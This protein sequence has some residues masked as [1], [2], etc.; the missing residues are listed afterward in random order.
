MFARIRVCSCALLILVA[1][2]P[3]RKEEPEYFLYIEYV[4]TLQQCVYVRVCFYG[5]V[6]KSKRE[7]E[8]ERRE[9]TASR[10]PRSPSTGQLE[11][12]GHRTRTSTSRSAKHRSPHRARILCVY[13]SIW[14]TVGNSSISEK[15]KAKG[16]KRAENQPEISRE[17]KR[18]RKIVRYIGEEGSKDR[19]DISQGIICD[20][21]DHLQ[22][23]ILLRE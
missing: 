13:I 17:R 14:H 20:R 18:E 22:L 10:S 3:S 12:H 15:E 5:R 7:R 2:S 19:W 8:R 1:P 4:Y 11:A 9:S 21:Y 16:I 23:C 6:K